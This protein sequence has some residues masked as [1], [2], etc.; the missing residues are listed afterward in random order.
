[1]RFVSL[2]ITSFITLSHQTLAHS[3]GHG[4]HDYELVKVTEV[5]GRQGVAVDSDHYYISG[6]LDLH[7]YDKDWNLLL[8]NTDP[9]SSLEKRANHLG[10]IAVHDG[11][12]YT[13]IEWF[14]D[15]RG[16]DIQIAVYDA[17][18]LEYLRTF[19]WDEGSGQVEVSG[20]S[21]DT[22]NN[23]VLMTDWVE[24]NYVYRY[25]LDDGSYMGKVK[26]LPSP[27]W[28]QGITVYDGSIWFTADDGNADRKEFDNLWSIKA[29]LEEGA[30]YIQHEHAFNATSDFL[31]YGEIE[32]LD[33]DEEA[34]ELLVHHN[35]GKMVDK[36]TPTGLYPGYDHE[37]WEVYTY[38]VTPREPSVE[39]LPESVVESI[40]ELVMNIFEG[41]DP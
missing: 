28:P 34:G 35:R 3:P 22:V 5:A 8:S 13:G 27:Q 12:I 4:Q 36:G 16:Y 14:E 17:E 18:T 2:F 38:K 23:L 41:M 10:D 31:D 26:L 32:G 30:E 15:G 25:S 19:D 6:S 33:F 39:D 29:T 1:M 40:T 9:F 24:G 11:E 21:V 7:K 20:L 37:V